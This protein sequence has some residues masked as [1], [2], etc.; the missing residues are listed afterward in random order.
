MDILPIPRAQFTLEMIHDP[1]NDS[2]NSLL[3]SIYSNL[4]MT[5]IKEAVYAMEETDKTKYD[6]ILEIASSYLQKAENNYHQRVSF[7]AI[8]QF[9]CLPLNLPL[10]LNM[11]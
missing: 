5:Y 2:P 10:K 9:S 4:G 7:D 8:G 11:I 6:K 3:G 1:M